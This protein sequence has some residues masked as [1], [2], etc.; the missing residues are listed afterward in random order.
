[1]AHR[2]HSLTDPL[3]PVRRA[4]TL[5]R[6]GSVPFVE[7]QLRR[8]F[9]TDWLAKARDAA[10][11]N[12]RGAAPSDGSIHWEPSSLFAVILGLW[13][14]PFGTTD[15]RV[16]TLVHE[17]RDFRNDYAHDKFDPANVGRLLDTTW[18]FLTAI[19]AK[20]AAEAEELLK[21]LRVEH[22]LPSSAT[23]SGA[24][25]ARFGSPMGLTTKRAYG[26]LTAFLIE[27][28][29]QNITL[30][31]AEVGEH[32][33]DHITAAP[34]GLPE[35]AFKHRPWWA[36]SA[37]HAHSRSWLD[38]GYRVRSVSLEDRVVCFSRTPVA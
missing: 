34:A 11:R 29:E 22:T 3:D 2:A 20:E 8:A 28:G 31:F 24:S 12:Y 6:A 27:R 38:A 35:S 14:T 33:T 36:N 18:R 26:R 17:L 4:F 32:V 9:P 23:T 21:G 5:V 30:T 37:G 1:M 25:R 7:S 15:R 10:Y 16:R 13:D 19:G